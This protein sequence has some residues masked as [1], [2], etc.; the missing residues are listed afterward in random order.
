VTA[1][2]VQHRGFTMVE[3][4]V[5]VAII[6]VVAA[7]GFSILSRGRPR[8]S[9]A[10]TASELHSI[11]HGAR[12]TAVSTG[13]D[14]GVLIFPGNATTQGRVF[15]Y[16]DGN[17]DFFAA[18]TVKFSDY[19]PTKRIAGSKSE[20]LTVFDLPTGISF[21]PET[22]MGTGATLPAPL[23]GV[24]V[25]KDCSFCDA[26]ATRRGAIRFDA[27]GRASFYNKDGVQAVEGGGA[28]SL[29]AADITGSKV[30]A[31]LAST[32]AVRL[33]NAD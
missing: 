17:L 1:R 25:T 24:V 10:S 28:I 30:L 14:V 29:T 33:V 21:G 11:I 4:L 22:G 3:L 32:G 9:L 12:M 2:P 13:H 5:A 6:G 26:A 23:D 27:L 7:A 15:V 20:I 18:G 8:A 16:E 31:I 19:D